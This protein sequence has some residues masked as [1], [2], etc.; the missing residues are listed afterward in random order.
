MEGTLDSSSH[1][2]WVQA[3]ILL[4]PAAIM[5]LGEN[6]TCGVEKAVQAASQNLSAGIIMG[7]LSSAIQPLTSGEVA[8]KRSSGAEKR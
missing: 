7:A 3:S 2:W 4:I 8:T 1:D 5:T 6:L